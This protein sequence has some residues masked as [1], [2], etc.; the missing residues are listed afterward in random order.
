MKETTEAAETSV[1]AKL[2]VLGQSPWLLLLFVWMVLLGGSPERLFTGPMLATQHVEVLPLQP[3]LYAEDGLWHFGLLLIAAVCLLQLV[4]CVRQ[5]AWR[6]PLAALL[7]LVSFLVVLGDESSHGPI[8]FLDLAAALGHWLLP[9]DDNGAGRLLSANGLWAGASFLAVF[10]PTIVLW[11]ERHST[12]DSVEPSFGSLVGLVL[13]IAC[14]LLARPES[15]G[16][17]FEQGHREFLL[18]PSE[19]AFLLA[20]IGSS[21]CSVSSLRRVGAYTLFLGLTWS[22]LVLLFPIVEVDEAWLPLEPATA[23]LTDSSVSTFFISSVTVLLVGVLLIAWW[24]AIQA[25]QKPDAPL[26]SPVFR[27]LALIP[28]GAYVLLPFTLDPFTWQS[29]ASN[30]LIALLLLV[31]LTGGPGCSRRR[32]AEHNIPVLNRSERANLKTLGQRFRL[33]WSPSLFRT[34][35]SRRRSDEHGRK[36]LFL[37]GPATRGGGVALS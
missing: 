20:G 35:D 14:L 33:G 17:L 34:E 6:A 19:L 7:G 24:R 37:H 36:Y 29:C 11:K 32:S 26:L 9:L 27:Y 31:A 3:S 12:T 4:R 10:W 28:V 21:L 5:R 13:G 25:F 1:I 30:W 16:S 18:M 22:S 8:F 23:G 2:K 15:H